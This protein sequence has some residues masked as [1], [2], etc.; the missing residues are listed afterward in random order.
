MISKFPYELVTKAI[1]DW[2]AFELQKKQIKFNDNISPFIQLQNYLSRVIPSKIRKVTISNSF[3]VSDENRKGFKIL[4]QAISEGNDL[5]KYLSKLTTNAEF[6]D[7]LFDYYGCVHFHLGE[8]LEYDNRVKC[9]FYERTCEVGLAIVTDEEVFFIEAKP[10]GKDYPETWTSLS[11][12][13]IVNKEKPYLI[14]KHKV[15]NMND[16]TPKISSH[17][18]ILALRNKGYGFAVTLSDGSS[19]MP[20]KLG[21]VSLAPLRNMKK[22]NQNYSAMHFLHQIKCTRVLHSIINEFLFNFKILKNC[23][24]TNVN[25]YDLASD[26]LKTF[27]GFKIKVDYLKEFTLYSYTDEFK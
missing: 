1:N 11:V 26:N 16:I 6:A 22:N 23:T 4:K 13:E 14:S 5:N 3:G 8:N 10:H 7:G 20:V 27:H 24:I 15:T 18:H 19:Y 25:I 21:P 2:A 9:E 12:L 17:E